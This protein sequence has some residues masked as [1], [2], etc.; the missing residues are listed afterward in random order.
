MSAP[1]THA[2][3]LLGAITSAQRDT[4][5]TVRHC[6]IVARAAARRAEEFA[7]A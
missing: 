6:A 7:A 3:L 2:I 1:L 5:A 4:I